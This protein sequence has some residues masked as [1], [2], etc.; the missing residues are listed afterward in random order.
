[1]SD[2]TETQ[3]LTVKMNNEPGTTELEVVSAKREGNHIKIELA[4]GELAVICDSGSMA[5]EEPYKWVNFL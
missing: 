3:T 1:M 4:T 2:N 5:E